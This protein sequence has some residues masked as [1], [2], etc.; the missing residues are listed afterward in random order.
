M[1][2]NDL[3]CVAKFCRNFVCGILQVYLFGPIFPAFIV[4]EFCG[5]IASGRKCVLIHIFP[6][7]KFGLFPIFP[8]FIVA[9]FCS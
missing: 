2:E 4:A 6:G 7:K 3:L 5:K 1:V 9:K 8:A